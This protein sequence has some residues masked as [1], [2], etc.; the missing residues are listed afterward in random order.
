M[1]QKKKNQIAYWLKIAVLGIILGFG[2]Q[3][4]R[5]WTEPT[6]TPPNGNVGAPINTGGNAQTKAGA[7]SSSTSLYAPQIDAANIYASNYI[8][9]PTLSATTIY[10]NGTGRTY[11]PGYAP[12]ACWWGEIANIACGSG[13]YV[14]QINFPSVLCCAF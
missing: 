7:F 5:A 13:F 4:V 11:W 2:L 12:F 9:V 10:F 6:Q 3:F 14:N 8:S 1:K